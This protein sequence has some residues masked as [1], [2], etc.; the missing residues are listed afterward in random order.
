VLEIRINDRK[1]IL[2]SLLVITMVIASVFGYGWIGHEESRT[3]GM[4]EK[5]E[6]SISQ[7]CGPQMDMIT[8]DGSIIFI[9]ND[10]HVI[11]LVNSDGGVVWTHTYDPGSSYPQIVD[12]HIYFIDVTENGNYSLECIRMDGSWKLSTPCPPIQNFIPGADGRIYATWSQNNA[13]IST[14]YCIEGGSVVWN[15]TRNGSL[16]ITNV[17]EIGNV[18]LRHSEGHVESTN[19][20]QMMMWDLDEAIMLSPNGSL[21][22]NVPFTSDGHLSSSFSEVTSNGTIVI[23]YDY[24]GWRESREYTI[25]GN[26]IW[27]SNVSIDQTNTYSYFGCQALGNNVESVFK[28]DWNDYTKGWIVRLNETWGGSMYDLN[29][30]E[31]FVSS[32]GQAFGFDPNGTIL[33]HIYTDMI[34]T[35]QCCIDFKLGLLVQSDNAITKIGKDGSYWT[36]DGIDSTIYGGRL[37]QNN[38]VYVLT[39]DKL[40]VLY[41]PTVSTPTEYL[42]AMLS[43]D[44]LIALSSVLWIADRIVKKPN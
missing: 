10:H 42:I 30:M 6:M 27:T 41:K 29:G 38:T 2:V 16:A 40:M 21:M 9:D 36:Y 37:G 33:W 43:V 11:S 32:D 4:G 25:S 5:W 23:I 34:G 18:L 24:R 8:S 20:S 44:M 39:S 15:F 1:L 19:F 17:W 28:V 12:G 22:W 26:L 14:V 35:T 13:S 31:I 3:G 7:N